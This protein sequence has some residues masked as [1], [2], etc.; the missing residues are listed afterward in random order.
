MVGYADRARPTD[1]DESVVTIS[2]IEFEARCLA[3]LKALEA[4]RL[5][6]VA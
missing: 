4:R 3:P 1:M 2:A 5:T 6:R